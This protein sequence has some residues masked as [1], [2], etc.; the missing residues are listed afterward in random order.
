LSFKSLKLLAQSSKI[1]Q[2]DDIRFS[3]LNVGP[4]YISDP[5]PLQKFLLLIVQKPL[6]WFLFKEIFFIIYFF[7]L[8]GVPSNGK[9]VTLNISPAPS[10]SDPVMIGVFTYTNP[11]PENNYELHMTKPNTHNRTKHIVRTRK[12][13]FSRK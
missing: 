2:G 11:F 4:K 5:K 7:R 9:A 8:L 13:A 10:A 1:Q 12:C 3:A 6:S